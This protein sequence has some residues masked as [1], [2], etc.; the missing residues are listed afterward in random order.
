MALGDGN[1]SQRVDG[2]K[3]VLFLYNDADRMQELTELSVPPTAPPTES[4]KNKYKIKAQPCCASAK[5]CHQWMVPARP[6]G[7][8]CRSPYPWD[9]RKLR[10]GPHVLARRFEAEERFRVFTIAYNARLVKQKEVPNTC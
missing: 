4:F 2:S 6:A 9:V 7:I 3:K 8:G 10:D 1:G 5:K